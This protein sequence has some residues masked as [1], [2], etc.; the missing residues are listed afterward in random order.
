MPGQQLSSLAG[1]GVGMTGRA[2]LSK[3]TVGRARTWSLAAIAALALSSLAPLV[4]AL[5]G[6]ASLGPTVPDSALALPGA[7]G[8]H[9]TAAV[10]TTQ[11]VNLEVVLASSHPAG[12]D[13][14]AEQ[15]SSPRS[16]LYHHFLTKSQFLARFGPSH[17]VVKEAIDWLAAQGFTVHQ[18]SPFSIEASGTVGT[19]QKS[20]GVRFGFFR[21]SNGSGYAAQGV[22]EVPEALVSQITGILGLDTLSGPQYQ[23]ARPLHL[24]RSPRLGRLGTGGHARLSA[25]SAASPTACST[26][27]QAA[28]GDSS[29]TID[30]VGS[31]Y[32]LGAL[33]S[34]GQDGA[35]VTVA[36]PE[37]GAISSADIQAFDQC[38]GITTQPQIVTV[39][40]GPSGDNSFVA[41]ADL[42][43]E[44]VAALAPAAAITVYEAPDSPND[45]NGLYDAI[46]RAVSDD[47]AK[48]I[49]ISLGECEVGVTDAGAMDNVFKQATLQG[50]SVLVASGDEGSED[51]YDG[52]SG[53]TGLSVDFPGSDPWAT[54]VGGTV[55]N[56]GSELA[57]N[58]CNG[59]GSVSCAENIYD[60]GGVGATGGGVSQLYSTAPT[61]QPVLAG[62]GGR[63][64]VPDVSA[65]AGSNFGDDIE[66]YVDGSWQAYLG[67]SL[68]A[69]VWAA[70][71][72][73][74]DST[75]TTATGSFDPALYS[76]Y[77]GLAA[78]GYGT[79][80]NPVS[81]GYVP[82]PAFQPEVG[83]ND[84][85][86]TNNG[87]YPVSPSYNLAT[88]IGSPIAPG[89]ACSQVGSGPYQGTAGQD[90][91][92]TGVGLEDA[93]IYFGAQQATVVSESGTSATV[94]VPAGQGQV[95]LSATSQVLGLSRDQAEFTYA[96]S[97]TSTTGTTATS[98]T[99]ASTA[100]ST[101]TGGGGSGPGG[102]FV[103]PPPG[104]TTTA[105]TAPVASP[106]TSTT[107]V[108][109]TAAPTTVAPVQGAHKTTHGY[110]LVNGKGQVFTFG[111]T[112]LVTAP[113]VPTGQRIVA[114]APT[115]D[116]GGYWL[117]SAQGRVFPAGDASSFGDLRTL[118]ISSSGH[119]PK[120]LSAPVVGIVPSADGRG[121][122]LVAADGG[123]FKFGDASSRGSCNRPG[124]CDGAVVA[125]MADPTGPGYWLVTAKGHVYSLGGAPAFGQ[126][127]TE[128]SL[129]RS[130]VVAAAPTP[131]GRGLWAL[132]ADGAL[133]AI[134]NAGLYAHPGG[135][136]KVT[137]PAGTAAIVAVHGLPGYWVVTVKGTVL[138][139]GSAPQEGDLAGQ[140]FAP[141][142]VAATGW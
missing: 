4:P 126:C 121:Y 26:A 35:G 77:G 134:G 49:S 19:V 5:A 91:T 2:S 85:T 133:C 24:S 88:G 72:A 141:P 76:L 129:H 6:A 34:A 113:K 41:E 90:I 79:A 75:C 119:G 30:Q 3:K 27:Q 94:L 58:D 68:A 78:H 57:W 16:G 98:S 29:Y 136:A 69:P 109:T 89:L 32:K 48:V 33:E 127:G 108:A 21:S 96:A 84:Y 123:V 135:S 115:P 139:Y 7:P 8:A 38:Y 70:L 65:E 101:S 28:Q 118:G 11:K 9:G 17:A 82:G 53:T 44:E 50:Q 95:E 102:G 23:A 66:V 81:Q 132:M 137:V 46:S 92:L 37:L 117:V 112:K 42:D 39:D 87:D 131:G 105:T 43:F 74:R 111:L 107:A 110:W 61:G 122:L 106:V 142:L 71:V 73:D 47:T 114:I 54:D 55:D 13:N 59:T 104:T 31:F 99:T 10:A 86:Q 36:L 97:T 116:F 83:T 125:A 25:S 62:T 63:R 93:S 67:T 14:L 52:Q 138:C 1:G 12:L 15:V 20:L 103:P 18:A 130:H 120:H 45:P 100:T 60:Q 128:V 80:F 140:R 124:K 22:P 51:C 40:S 64:E 56:G